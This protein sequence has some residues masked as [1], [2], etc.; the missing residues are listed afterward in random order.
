MGSDI[1]QNNFYL[2]EK[3]II[4]QTPDHNYFRTIM[5]FSRIKNL[6]PYKYE[7]MILHEDGDYTGEFMEL[8]KDYYVN[9]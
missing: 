4:K 6:A 1:L 2:K 3:L 7:L 8:M 9:L 5:H